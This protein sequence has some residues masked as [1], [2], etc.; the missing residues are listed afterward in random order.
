MVDAS[1]R[2]VGEKVK[3]VSMAEICIANRVAL[4]VKIFCWLTGKLEGTR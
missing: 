3:P 2:E 1:E 4:M